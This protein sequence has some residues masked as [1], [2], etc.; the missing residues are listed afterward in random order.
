[1]GNIIERL[2]PNVYWDTVWEA[3]I[4]TLNMTGISL[5]LTALIGIPLGIL[6]YMTDRGNVWE[7]RTFYT[8]TGT[9]VNI[10]RSIPFIILIILLIPYVRAIMGSALGI[11]SAIPALVIGAA[12]FYARLVEIALREIPKGIV[13]AAK[14][15]GASNYMIILKVLLPESRPALLSGITVTGIAL[16]GYTAMAGIVGAGGLG[17]LAFRDGY[18]RGHQDVIWICT[19]IIILLVQIFQTIGDLIVKKID[20]R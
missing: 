13:E 9:I 2:L 10:L 18:Q 6:L 4:E 16:I 7:N 8:I 15:M 12:P 11:K 20:K 5:L 17:Y 3:T 14:A 19:I 1:M